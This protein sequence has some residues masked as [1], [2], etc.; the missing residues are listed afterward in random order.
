MVKGLV[1]VGPALFVPIGEIVSVQ[2]V[3]EESV[4]ASA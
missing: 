3:A 4:P 2:Y 1:Q